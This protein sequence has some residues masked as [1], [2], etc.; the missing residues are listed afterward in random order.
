MLS[1][2]IKLPIFKRIIP[3]LGIH[4]MKLLKKNKGYFKINNIAMYLDFLDPIDREIILYKKYEDEEIKYLIILIRKYSVTKF[5][6]VGSNCGYYSIR[7]INEFPKLEITAFEPNKEAYLKFNKTIK[8][9]SDFLGK[10]KI[11]NF[12]LSNKNSVLKMKFLKKNGYNQTGGSSVV[13]DND[14]IGTN[15]FLANFKTGDS[16][17]NLKNQI[18]C[19]KID[20][21]RHEFDVLSGLNNVFKENKI[22]LLIE[23][24]EKNFYK[25]NSFL[26][27]LGFELN[28]SIQNR[29]NY[30]YKNF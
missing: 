23:I 17:L 26:K 18:L 14:Y 16:V 9:N 11:K 22:I 30:F 15:T 21:E 25:C 7:L 13:D 29:S 2:L 27:K 8:K 20:V 19:F 4:I 28:K 5:F 24:Y 10:I 1:K 3:S 12:G 6:D